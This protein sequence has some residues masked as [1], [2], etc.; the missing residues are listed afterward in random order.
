MHVL[1][2][3][4]L[5]LEQESMDHLDA[6][7]AGD[8]RYRGLHIFSSEKKSELCICF[9]Q[10][11]TM[12]MCIWRYYNGLI[13]TPGVQLSKQVRASRTCADIKLTERKSMICKL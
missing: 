8:A 11:I 7:L 10:K 5:E 4:W 6:R 2:E 9:K 1:G 13:N 3:E 12:G